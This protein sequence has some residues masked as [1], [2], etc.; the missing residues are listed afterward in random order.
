VDGDQKKRHSRYSYTGPI[1]D[2]QVTPRDRRSYNIYNDADSQA[3]I[4]RMLSARQK[5]LSEAQAHAE[6]ILQH[7]ALRDDDSVYDE[8]S[9]R[10]RALAALEGGTSAHP[11]T[12][13]EERPRPL[14]SPV[15]Y[16]DWWKTH[17]FSEP[18][19]N[20]K[21]NVTP[22][23]E[24]EKGLPDEHQRPPEPVEPEKRNLQ[25]Y[26]RPNWDQSSQIGES[27]PK[28]F[29]FANLRRVTSVRRKGAE[30]K[31]VSKNISNGMGNG[32]G[33]RESVRKSVQPGLVAET[34]VSPV[35]QSPVLAPVMRETKANR[36]MSFFAFFKR[37]SKREVA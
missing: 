20:R 18:S 19:D 33:N 3:N 12:R 32:N 25:P 2:F 35:Q 36:R 5:R 15:G 10:E 14:A 4:Q 8:L 1:P 34:T 21:E 29:S 11:S 28:R 6:A 17:D 30:G 31:A 22:A 23:G 7:P 9:A 24:I 26:D 13:G 16:R 27:T 37:R